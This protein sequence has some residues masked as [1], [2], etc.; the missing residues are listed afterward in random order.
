MNV[1]SAIEIYTTV[2]GWL[3]YDGIWDILSDTGLL[4]VPLVAA[5]IRNWGFAWRMQG[6]EAAETIIRNNWMDIII[7]MT[8]IA[9]AG[10]PVVTVSPAG[11]SHTTP[12]GG[13][14]VSGGSTGTLY[15]KAFAAIDGQSA[16]VPVWWDATLAIANGINNAAIALIPCSP[17]LRTYAY[18]L[19]NARVSDPDMRR[20]LELFT[21]DCWQ[22]AR[23]KFMAEHT[24]LP[25]T[26]APEDIDW[27]VPHQANIRIID[28]TAKHA[29]IPAEKVLVTVD[30]YGNT[31][32]ASIPMALAYAESTGRLKPGMLVLLVAFG[33][34]F[35]WGSAVIRW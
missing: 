4:Y 35:T 10:V 12:C 13:T 26:Y 3:L 15:D 9:L 11:I 17:D 5:F 14:P 33:A 28:S 25:A 19:D 31:S 18:R 23:A 22:K 21:R 24:V 6:I 29:G 32:A 34:G 20:Q 1:S 16:Q 27:L 2:L 7:M 8:V 30:R